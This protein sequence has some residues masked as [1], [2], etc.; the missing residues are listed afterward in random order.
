MKGSKEPQQNASCKNLNLVDDGIAL[1]N[2][3]S[4]RGRMNED[5]PRQPMQIPE[6]KR[7]R[8]IGFK[9]KRLLMYSE[10]ALELRFTWEEAQDLLRPPPSLK[11]SIVT[12]EGH[13]FE[14]YE[15]SVSRPV[16]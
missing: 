9:S 14:E 2:S 1:H 15:V 12:I 8:N 10:E 4:Y 13:D 5:S 7:T 16:L 11:P 3:D 6:K